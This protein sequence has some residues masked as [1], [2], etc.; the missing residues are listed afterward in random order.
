M[1]AIWINF[2]QPLPLHVRVLRYALLICGALLLLLVFAQHRQLTKVGT[3]LAWQLQDAQGRPPAPLATQRFN[4]TQ[5]AEA[6]EE[7]RKRAAAVLR[8]LDLPW[9]ALFSALES[10]IDNDIVILSVAPNPQGGSLAL[11]A[12]ATDTDAAIDFADRLKSGR[13]LTDIH[14]VQ[15]D[16]GEDGQRFPLQFSL[17]ADWKVQ[18]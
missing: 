10:A 11:K 17:S 16:P 12:M 8:E 9:N 13:L 14:M 1:K 6:A 18:P 2:V 3:A 15:E 5:T 7:T 4:D